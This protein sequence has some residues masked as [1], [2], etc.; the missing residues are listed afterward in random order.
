M[1]GRACKK[2]NG[3][4]GVKKVL[5]GA[6][7]D[8]A[9]SKPAAPPAP[10]PAPK[11]E[12]KSSRS[13]SSAAP[14][15][16]DA[17]PPKKSREPSEK[18]EKPS[19]KPE[20]SAEKEKSSSSRSKSKAPEEPPAKPSSKKKEE[21]PPPAPAEEKRSR[22]KPPPPP[23]VDEAPPAAEPAGRSVSPGAD[24]ALNRTGGAPKFQRPTSAR[25]A[26]PRVP[27]AQQP[28]SVL[29]GGLRPGTAQR[30]PPAAADKVSKPVA[31]IAD[32]A[33][34]DSDDEVE[35]VHEQE[36]AT[37]GPTVMGE[38]GVL[39]QDILKVENDLKVIGLATTQDNKDTSDQGGGT[40]IILKRL[41]K[42]GAAGP[43]AGAG[44]RGHDP[45]AVRDLVQ[46]LCQSSTPLAKSM[47]YLQED[48]ENMRKEYKFWITEKRMYQDELARELRM[49]GEAANIDAQLADLDGQIKQARDRII[50]LKGQILRNDE[51]LGKL[52]A[53][54]TS[55]R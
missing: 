12:K 26:P 24:D 36:R 50:G 53:M 55:G 25:K 52:L 20:K 6:T 49:Q 10:E 51:T 42:P 47:D 23:A 3:A 4:D 18:P 32:N 39:V 14:A 43:G 44:A 13:S 11:E 7:T 48:I 5:G 15:A 46:K 8:A 35:V 45:S 33:R 22:S 29:G 19:E 34:G 2:G 16:P 37:G 30:R 1:L 41:G 40:G 17:A 27:Q 9:P 38:K 31:V 54:A 21:P 28:T